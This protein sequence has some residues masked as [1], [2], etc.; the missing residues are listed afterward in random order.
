MKVEK[1]FF[2]L[3]AIFI[4]VSCDPGQVLI[5]SAENKPNNSVTVYA[6]SK[7]FGRYEKNNPDSEKV[8]IR[9]P[10]LNEP[11]KRDSTIS[12]GI[13]V[14]GNPEILSLANNIDSIIISNHADKIFLKDKT[15]ITNYLLKN[16]SGFANSILTIR[17]K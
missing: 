15:D 10:P 4:F 8:I 16:R 7:I 13:G 14:W 5:I 2:M 1:I 17:A 9:I 6:N 12:Y 3:W 11:S